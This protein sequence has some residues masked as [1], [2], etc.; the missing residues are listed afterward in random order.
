MI[1]KKELLILFV[2]IRPK[3][4]VRKLENV[5]VHKYVRQE[6]EPQDVLDSTPFSAAQNNSHE[7]VQQQC[8]LWENDS[9]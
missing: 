8:V 3:I 9:E 5:L 1:K 7:T 4:F 6:V 2:F